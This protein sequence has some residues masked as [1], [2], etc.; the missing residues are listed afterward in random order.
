MEWRSIASSDGSSSTV[1]EA[2]AKSALCL[3][4]SFTPKNLASI[5]PASRSLPF[6]S[7]FPCPLPECDLPANQRSRATYSLILEEERTAP[8]RSFFRSHYWTRYSMK[9]RSRPLPS[10]PCPFDPA[11]AVILSSGCSYN[12]HP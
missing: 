2:A 7:V 12:A 3:T 9:L 1:A 4:L 8:R 6:R 5:C 10:S 11:F